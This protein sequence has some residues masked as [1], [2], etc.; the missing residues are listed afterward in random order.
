MTCLHKCLYA[1]NNSAL[2]VIDTRSFVISETLNYFTA[3]GNGVFNNIT[4]TLYITHNS[5]VYILNTTAVLQTVVNIGFP[6][7]YADINVTTNVLYISSLNST[8]IAILDCNTLLFTTINLNSSAS[9]AG[10]AVNAYLQ[11]YYVVDHNNNALLVYKE[12]TNVQ[13]TSIS[14]QS[15]PTN[16]VI[17]CYTNN[18]YVA[19]TIAGTISVINNS[20]VVV[21]TITGFVTPAG[22]AIN[23]IT[24]YLF[25]VDTNTNLISSID[26]ST[27]KINKTSTS[28]DNK[29]LGSICVDDMNNTVCVC[30]TFSIYKFD[31]LFVQEINQIILGFT[32]TALLNAKLATML[33]SAVST[34]QVLPPS[35]PPSPPLPP[36]PTIPSFVFV[37][38]QS[39]Q[40]LPSTYNSI[41][42]PQLV[43]SSGSS[44]TYN[45]QSGVFTL[46]SGVTY[47][48]TC[49]IGSVI[50]SG[51]SGNS[52]VAFAWY[53]ILLQKTLGVG[54]ELVFDPSG[55]T[56][57]NG[58][59]CVFVYTP[60]NKCICF[61]C[62]NL[63]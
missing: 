56:S 10:I 40:P 49:G 3:L 17:N 23:S 51:A 5:D 24:N 22:I 43:G 48:L 55:D 45:S 32:P 34:P 19:N 9:S 54:E 7:Y 28:T 8:Q 62:T 20:N 31:A 13:V 63:Y 47:K 2:S 16:V 60:Y 52:S 46:V 29:L 25:V 37:C 44:I 58:G 42:F 61:C 53:D 21:F 1:F 4:N 38:L 11:F 26:C 36:T 50:N 6:V 30:A 18:V 33:S 57:R 14:V 15:G 39:G 59:P 41:I 12:Q 27:N 35:P